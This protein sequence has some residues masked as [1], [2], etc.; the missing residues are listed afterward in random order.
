MAKYRNPWSA[1]GYGPT[2]YETDKRPTIYRGYEIYQRVPGAFDLVF[3]GTC[4]RQMAGLNGAKMAADAH[5]E[6]RTYPEGHEFP[7]I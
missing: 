4:I 1:D 5:A 7:T 2:F 3:N 6:G